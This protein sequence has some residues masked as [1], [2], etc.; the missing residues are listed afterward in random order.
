M[1]LPD[2]STNYRVNFI[3]FH[4]A[5]VHMMDLRPFEKQYFE[6]FDDYNETLKMF[7]SYGNCYTALHNGNVACCFGAVPL[8]RGTAEGWMLT[9]YIVESNPISLTRGARRY[10]NKIAI[11]MQLHRLQ[12]VVDN[13]NVLAIRWT[14]ALG[15]TEEGLMKNYGPDKS[16]HFMFARY[17]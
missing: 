17:F 6:W 7:A 5:H 3:P 4:W 14:K 12:F 9:S 10:I 1:S 2:I 16:D 8:N 15:F 13:S 11:D